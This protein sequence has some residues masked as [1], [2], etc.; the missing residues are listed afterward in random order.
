MVVGILNRTSCRRSVMTIRGTSSTI[1]HSLSTPAGCAHRDYFDWDA[2]RSF[3]PALSFAMLSQ[4]D[5]LSG[6][7]FDYQTFEGNTLDIAFPLFRQCAVDLT[8]TT[9]ACRP[10]HGSSHLVDPLFFRGSVS[11]GLSPFASFD[12]LAILTSLSR[13]PAIPINLS[14]IMNSRSS[15]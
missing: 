14:R 12:V 4:H 10:Y 9:I 6:S 3:Y 1:R 8:S 13:S 5:N 7:P 15:N 2:Q 11:T